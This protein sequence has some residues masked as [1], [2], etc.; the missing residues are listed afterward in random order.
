MQ[1]VQSCCAGLC[2]RTSLLEAKP[3]S[4]AHKPDLDASVALNFK[5]NEDKY[6]RL[7]HF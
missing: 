1:T 6:H 4:F 3:N 2:F 7:E 5:Q